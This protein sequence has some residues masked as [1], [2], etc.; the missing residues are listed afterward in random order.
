VHEIRVRDLGTGYAA[1]R[2]LVPFYRTSNE[3][4]FLRVEL[5]STGVAGLIIDRFRFENE[6]AGRLFGGEFDAEIARQASACWSARCIRTYFNDEP[7]YSEWE[8]WRYVDSVLASRLGRRGLTSLYWGIDREMVRRWATYVQP[9]EVLIDP[10][11]LDAAA[12]QVPD[13]PRDAPAGHGVPPYDPGQYAASIRESAGR[14]C[15]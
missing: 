5:E 8:A 13:L 1:H 7:E 9:A 15:R 11:P 10:Y 6:R 3:R 4:A 2:G 14:V 12:L